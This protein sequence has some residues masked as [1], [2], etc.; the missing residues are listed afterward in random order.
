MITFIIS[1]LWH[2]ADVTFIIWGGI[3][4]IFLILEKITNFET[5]KIPGTIKTILIFII[6]TIAWVFFRSGSLHDSILIINRIFEFK[7]G[8]YIDSSTMFF[9]IISLFLL[10]VNDLL[11]EY[12]WKKQLFDGSISVASVMYFIIII[13]TVLYLGV[14]D[15]GQ[16]IYFQF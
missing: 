7:P 3:H 11:A 10:F 8:L 6:V 16:F 14:L 2:G 12:Y 13:F 4:G 15:G 9:S 1:G 5:T